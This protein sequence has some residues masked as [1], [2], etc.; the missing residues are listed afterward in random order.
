MFDRPNLISN[1]LRISSDFSSQI[2][3]FGLSNASHSSSPQKPSIFPKEYPVSTLQI[4]PSILSTIIVV[5]WLVLLSYHSVDVF[6][7]DL[8]D[9]RFISCLIVFILAFS[10]HATRRVDQDQQTL[11]ITKVAWAL[12]SFWALRP[13]DPAGKAVAFGT[14]LHTRWV[15]WLALQPLSVVNSQ[16]QHH[17]DLLTLWS[18]SRR[19]GISGGPIHAL[20]S[21]HHPSSATLYLSESL[22]PS[23]LQVIMA[24]RQGFPFDCSCS[25]RGRERVV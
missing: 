18:L 1:F 2:S 19:F 8:P 23:L 4:F 13:D 3:G 7:P 6:L 9:L 10:C 21:S 17:L 11:V 24:T 12:S 16:K 15:R 25:G 5:Y 20:K 22:F 14:P